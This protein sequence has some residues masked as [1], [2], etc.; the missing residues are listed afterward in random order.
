MRVRMTFLLTTAVLLSSLAAWSQT[1]PSLNRLIDPL[2]VEPIDKVSAKIDNVQRVP[3]SGNVY[4]LATSANMVGAVL[5]DQPMAKMVLVLR[6]D[7]SQELALEELIRAQQDPNSPYYH[8]WLTPESFG[9]R[10]GVSQN[11]LAQIVSWLETQGMKV[12]EIP[13]TSDYRACEVCSQP[14]V[15]AHGARLLARGTRRKSWP[16]SEL[17]RER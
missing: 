14:E 11:D 1:T 6:P 7:A 13:D 3:L 10:F 8:Q 12:D 2:A 16:T 17:H 4:P 15:G 9:E 5:P